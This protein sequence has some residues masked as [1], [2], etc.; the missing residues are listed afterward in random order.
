MLRSYV[1]SRHTGFR[2]PFEMCHLETSGPLILKSSTWN[3][4]PFSLG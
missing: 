4:I 1:F 3:I 2:S